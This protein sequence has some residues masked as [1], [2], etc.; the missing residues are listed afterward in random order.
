ML[1]IEVEI[2]MEGTGL[3]GVFYVN[4]NYILISTG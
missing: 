3:P 2:A 4:I 1:P